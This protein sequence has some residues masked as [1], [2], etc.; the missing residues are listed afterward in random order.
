MALRVYGQ[1]IAHI[2]LFNTL[3]FVTSGDYFRL[4]LIPMII[5][6]P[7]I[8][9]LIRN[10]AI[11]IRSV[12]LVGLTFSLLYRVFDVLRCVEYE[13]ECED[14]VFDPIDDDAEFLH[15]SSSSLRRIPSWYPFRYCSFWTSSFPYF[16]LISVFGVSA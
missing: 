16:E 11:P 7:T 9:R 6:T 12:I 4:Y 14:K 8:I 5:A 1:G 2:H 13:I 10:V 15:Y 3:Y